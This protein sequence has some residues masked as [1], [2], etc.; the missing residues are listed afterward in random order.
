M[1]ALDNTEVT[2]LC[3]WCE[4]SEPTI[5][6]KNCKAHYCEECD[7]DYHKKG[8]PKDHE[9]VK[10]AGNNWKGGKSIINRMCSVHKSNPIEA[11]CEDEKSI[12]ITIILT[13]IIIIIIITLFIIIMISRIMLF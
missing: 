3:S 4:E 10:V 13:L 5:Y 6:C 1:S 12:N 8:K 11:F 2:G 9:R 7:S